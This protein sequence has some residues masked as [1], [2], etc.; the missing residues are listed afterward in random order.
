MDRREDRRDRTRRVAESR[1]RDRLFWVGRDHLGWHLGSP[2]YFAKSTPLHCDCRK[3]R[4]GAPKRPWG[5]CC[6]NS[7]DRI[8]AWRWEARE[9]NR[10]AVRFWE[11]WDD[12]DLALRG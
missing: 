12:D 2:F 10:L 8:Y 11:D 7:R 3:R 1:L 4:H 6:I 5:M 9:L